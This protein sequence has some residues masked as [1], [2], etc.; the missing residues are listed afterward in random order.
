MCNT[1]K[2]KQC[3]SSELHGWKKSEILWLIVASFVILFLSLYW[4]ENLVGIISAL[5]GVWCVILTGMGRRSSYVFGIV[6]VILYAWIAF[7]AKYYGDV[8]LN[9]L[10][11]LPMS[12]IG[13]F[14]WGRHLSSSG[15]EVEKRRL[16][17]KNTVLVF[18]VTGAAV[19]GYG[20]VLKK[21][22]G[23]LPF[24]DSCSTVLSIVAQILCNRRYAEQ[25]LLWIVVDVVTVIMW[26]FAFFNGGESIATL[27][28][29]SVYL[30]NA[31]FMYIRWEKEAKNAV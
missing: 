30:L 10:Y 4:G 20:L 17:L 22:K 14:E 25:W 7:G 5:T 27:L 3:L 26:I 29:W 31:V 11:F 24:V 18:L 12:F 8:M 15:G 23:S 21:L 13:F 28:M 6:N 2:V 1:K 9:L 19:F 16:P